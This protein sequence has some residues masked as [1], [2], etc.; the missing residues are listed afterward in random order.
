MKKRRLKITDEK[1]VLWEMFYYKISMDERNIKHSAGL[2]V[3]DKKIVTIFN[4]QKIYSG[5]RFK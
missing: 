1:K 4:S 2:N 3:W 5:Y